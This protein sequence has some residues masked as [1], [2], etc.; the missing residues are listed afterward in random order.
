MK[1]P[2]K[3]LLIMGLACVFTT[4]LFASHSLADEITQS[5]AT[6]SENLATTEQSNA[7]TE[8]TESSTAPATSTSDTSTIDIATLNVKE[9]ITVVQNTTF[10]NSI[11]FVSATD[12]RGK[13]LVVDDLNITG[14]VDTT[15]IGTYDLKVTNGSL[16]K[17][18]KVTVTADKT[19]L[20]LKSSVSAMQNSTFKN[21][22]IFD[23]AT[24]S[25]GNKLTL[26]D[27]KITG[28][29]DTSK[30]GN[31]VLTV[32]NGSITKTIT[33]TVKADLTTLN[34]KN[35]SL[36]QGSSFNYASFF[37]SAADSNGKALKVTDL[38]VTGSVTTGKIGTYTLTVTNG[39]LVKKVTVTVTAIPIKKVA[40]Y[41]MYNPDSYEH[42]YT[43]D[44]YERSVLVK[45]GWTCEGTA[46]YAPDRGNA[47]YRLYLGTV[48]E[49][50]YSTSLYEQNVLV[51]RGWKYEG[52]A[53]YSGGTV[54]TYR[55]YNSGIKKHNFTTDSYEQKVLTTQ[56][57]WKNEGVAWYVY[58]TGDKNG[59]EVGKK[60]GWYSVG[61]TLK[62]YNANTSSYTKQF[63]MPYY[64]QRDTRW[65]N[66]YYAGYTLGNTGCGMASIAMV[67]SG[68]GKTIT[69]V[70][71]ADYAHT[72]G[73]FDRYPEVGSAQ[74]DLTMV[75][76]H[77]GINYK[78]MS[79][80]S[81]LASYLS[82][83]YPTTV[84]LDLGNGVRHIVVLRGYSGGY[85]TV[86]D[87]WNGV[88]FS[89]RHS[90]SQIW[91][92]LS[93]KADNKNMGASAAVVYIS[94]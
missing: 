80:S 76:S 33:V 91:S 73:S 12:S 38:K 49:H 81:Q 51:S 68:F 43:K 32:A 45:R 86:T 21:D 10:E 93:W 85:T 90:V 64:S 26:A 7:S 77:W 94:K 56:R 3:A 69:P 13:G 1:S 53:F 79:L 16:E 28:T 46:W 84:C 23:S 17:T 36:T 83:G 5:S 15:K 37:I 62:Y 87:P 42:F 63:S 82:Q 39:S 88:I 25:L 72:Y 70:Q 75:A 65:V 48:G 30:A 78:V 24:D 47:I 11:F 34:V 4:P 31:Y 19:S 18:I 57:G 22:M 9:N 58:Q 74:S 44:Y 67:V 92:L 27:L 50:F 20:N 54:K 41:R 6:L 59:A 89:G 71:A 40:V 55:A 29:V 61:G 66:K 52:I 8:T 2:N 60:S 14:N 35:V